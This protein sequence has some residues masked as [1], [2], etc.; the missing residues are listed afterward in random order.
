MTPADSTIVRM[1]TSR[2]CLTVRLEGAAWVARLDGET[3][4]E[5]TDAREAARALWAATFPGA[6][7]PDS[8]GT[9]GPWAV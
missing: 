3:P 7:L 5:G 9:R 8:P 2:G 1:L 4:T 6:C